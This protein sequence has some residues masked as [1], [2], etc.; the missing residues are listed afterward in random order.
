[1]EKIAVG[2]QAHYENQWENNG[3][4]ITELTGR[5][6][7]VWKN[8]EVVK[9]THTLEEAEAFTNPPAAVYELSAADME[10]P[11]TS[12][13]ERRAAEDGIFALMPDEESHTMILAPWREG[14][15]GIKL[16]VKTAKIL[17]AMLDHQIKEWL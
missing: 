2:K 8:K 4:I 15:T 10:K 9:T 12:E 13:E 6:F 1:V 3:F 17:I 11:I 7:I 5:C 16:T 14:E